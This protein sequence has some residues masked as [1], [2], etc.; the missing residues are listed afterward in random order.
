MPVCA[1]LAPFRESARSKSLSAFSHEC[2]SLALPHVGTETKPIPE[3]ETMKSMSFGE[4][5]SA[6]EVLGQY[7]L[8]DRQR[9][10]AVQGIEMRARHAPFNAYQAAHCAASRVEQQDE[11]FRSRLTAAIIALMKD[12]DPDLDAPARVPGRPP[13]WNVL[14]REDIDETLAIRPLA[15]L[16]GSPGKVRLS[17]G[18]HRDGHW[19]PFTHHESGS[20]DAFLSAALLPAHAAGGDL[21]DEIRPRIQA[22][23]EGAAPG[24]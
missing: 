3:G 5:I 15:G 12:A 21:R 7:D 22:E 2:V 20:L 8:S 17:W 24:L 16:K 18:W 1:R 23:S 14:H 10:I 9:A 13:M 11:E 19:N 6:E 4:T